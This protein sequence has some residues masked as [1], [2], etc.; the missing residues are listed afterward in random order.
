[1]SD[2]QE[3]LM[4]I[5]EHLQNGLR[6]PTIAK[7]MRLTEWQVLGPLYNRGLTVGTFR[8]GVIAVRPMREVARLFGVSKNTV[9]RWIRDGYLKP[10]GQ[11]KKQQALFFT[12]LILIDFIDNRSTWP[13]WDAERITDEDWRDYAL[14]QRRKAGGAWVQVRDIAVQQHYHPRAAAGLVK[15]GLF[16]GA[17]LI[18][19]AYYVWR[20][21]H[22]EP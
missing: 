8:R 20:K 9:L 15:R 22:G 17:V 3:R 11:R 12:D 5:T 13:L 21:D 2:M 1:M 18:R 7:R 10:V 16:P 14:E 4:L 6:V 19:D